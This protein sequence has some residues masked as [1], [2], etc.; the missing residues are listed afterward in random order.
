VS[1]PVPLQTERLT[2]RA[3][4]P[5]AA[6]TINAAIRDSFPELSAWLPWADHVPTIEETR[7]HLSAALTAFN[8]GQDWGLFVWDSG[9][10]EFLG[11]V[12]LHARLADATRREIGYWIR[13]SAAGRGYATEA[14]R[15]VSSTALERLSLSSVEIHVNARNVASQKVALNAGFVF[16]GEVSG[17]PESDGRPSRMLVY[18]LEALSGR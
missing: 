12:G 4:D 9:R 2:L 18:V 5:A 3:P 15:A 11:A 8:G 13:T 16:T 7:D 10:E 1:F 14:V 6:E 17:R